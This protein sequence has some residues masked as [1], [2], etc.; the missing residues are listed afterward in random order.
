[1]WAYGAGWSAL[2][3]ATCTRPDALGTLT[4][5][6]ASEAWTRHAMATRPLSADEQ[7][8]ANRFWLAWLP[9][10]A[11]TLMAPPSATELLVTLLGPSARSRNAVAVH[12]GNPCGLRLWVVG[13]MPN[14]ALV[15]PAGVAVSQRLFFLE[16]L[17]TW[18]AGSGG[19]F[20][21]AILRTTVR[22]DGRPL[23][24]GSDWCVLKTLLQPE[25]VRNGGKMR[26]RARCPLSCMHVHGSRL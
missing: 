20:T 11:S 12:I 16:E 5:S 1:M 4:A 3:P 7:L 15:G 18:L 17:P 19:V 23:V 26:V 6:A 14:G 10:P 2:A 24:R 13:R 25:D 21:K 9:R 8:A 22:A